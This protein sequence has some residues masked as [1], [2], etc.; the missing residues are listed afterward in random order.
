MPQSILSFPET[1]AVLVVVGV[2]VCAP[3]P[4]QVLLHG[5]LQCRLGV[6]LLTRGSVEVLGGSVEALQEDN[7]VARVLARAL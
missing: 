2:S 7:S 4:L 1:A 5:P 3:R 6:L